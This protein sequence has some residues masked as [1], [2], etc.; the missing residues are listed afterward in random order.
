[1][2][3]YEKLANLIF[4][5][6]TETIEDLE[7]RY[8]ARDLP[9]GAKVT[10]FAPSPTGFL[11]TGSLFASMISR[12]MAKDSNGVFYTRL[13]DTDQKREVAG[14]GDSLIDQLNK[15]GVT[16]DEGYLGTDKEKGNYGPYVQ[17]LRAN[18]YKVVIKY[19]LANNMAYPCFCSPEELS[20]MRKVQEAKKENF[21]YYAE[22]AK[23]SKLSAEEAIERIEK[24]ENFVIRFRSQ[25][26][27]HNKVAIDDAIRGHIEMAE[28][29]QHLVIYKSDGLPT[30]HFAHLVDD[31]FMRTTHVT[32]GEEWMPSLPMHIELFNSMNWQAPTYAHLPVIMKLDNGN[33]RKLS[34]RKD[35]EAAVSFFLE[36]GYPIEGFMEYLY[37][38][39]NSNYEA[40]RIEN[41]DLDKDEFK[42][43]F[44]KMSLD[45]ALFDLAKVQ[46]L[47]KEKLGRMNTETFFNESRQWASVYSPELFELI[48]E[49]PGFYK[50]IV[51]IER[52]KE[53]PRKDYEKYSDILPLIKFFYNN[54]YNELV[55]E[56]IVPENYTQ[57]N[58][59]EV[60]TKYVESF[61]LSLS[62]EDWFNHMK[63]VAVE[64][65]YATNR[66]DYKKNPEAYKG[67]VSDV[68]AILRLVVTL[69]L[70][71]P[72]LYFVM[73]ILGK[74]EVTRRIKNFIK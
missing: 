26:D 29:D 61:D 19:M 36:Q 32:R 45:G 55:K 27:Y 49:N 58:I 30:Y 33:R 37:T 5:D 60:L 67:Q 56:L 9:E 16:P 23:C 46:F 69:R 43:S 20:E 59:N 66:K 71:S 41:P 10:R 42:F 35:L 51:S 14:S 57:E 18:I 25:G 17:S 64:C 44:D 72:N 24:G 12:K 47:C 6:I 2:N 54:Y 11:H 21:G 70:Q 34:K 7:K 53:N 39:A 65:G 68:A 1:M 22:Y 28:N 38:I 15:F 8:P 48:E 63:E 50:Q 52:E 74:E 13:E 31:H 62:E 73:Q 40:W 3:N 4:P